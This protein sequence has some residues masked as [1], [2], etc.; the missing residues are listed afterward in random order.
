MIPLTCARCGGW[1]SSA[2]KGL[3]DG[4]K[5]VPKTASTNEYVHENEARCRAIQARRS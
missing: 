5:L 1:L 3:P 4:Y 2:G